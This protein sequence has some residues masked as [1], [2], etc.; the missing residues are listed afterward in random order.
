MRRSH[1]LLDYQ[2][3]PK[4]FPALAEMSTQAFSLPGTREIGRSMLVNPKT[5]CGTVPVI[6]AV[7]HHIV[8][9]TAMDAG[10]CNS[11]P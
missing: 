9:S 8:R 5:W 2:I 6:L 11:S 1:A 3:T 10:S 4:N 7:G